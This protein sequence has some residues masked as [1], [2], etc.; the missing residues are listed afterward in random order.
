MNFTLDYNSFFTGIKSKTFEPIPEKKTVSEIY[1]DGLLKIAVI[2]AEYYTKNGKGFVTS[3]LK[4]KSIRT[5][6]AAVLNE[7][8][9]IQRYDPDEKICDYVG[10][11]RL[12]EKQT[13]LLARTLKMI[14]LIT[15]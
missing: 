12:D 3:F 2:Y 1:S 9:K 4:F 13:R 5:Q 8:E 7:F 11:L 10:K 14:K 6:C 15:E